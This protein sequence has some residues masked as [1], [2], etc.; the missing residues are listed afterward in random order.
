MSAEQLDLI[1]FEEEKEE[2]KVEIKYAKEDDGLSYK[3]ENCMDRPGGCNQCSFG[4]K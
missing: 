4:K 1:N 2:K 3:C